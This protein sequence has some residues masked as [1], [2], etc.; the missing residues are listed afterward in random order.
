[1]KIGI[2]G[3]GGMATSLGGSF[4]RAGHSVFLGGRRVEAAAAAAAA[5]GAAGHGDLSSAASYGEVLLVAVPPDAAPSLGGLLT[6]QVV[7]DCT[8]PLGADLMLTLPP[9]DSVTRRL[10]SAAPGARVVKAFNLCHASV[11]TMSPPVFEGA[12]LVVPFC[13]DPAATAA[14]TALI[15][16]MGCVPA[17][18]GGL[19]R[20]AYLEATAAL[21]IGIWFGGGQARAAFPSGPDRN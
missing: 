15:R 8:N 13:G 5:I 10:A 12:P 16:S 1:M 4:V 6:G 9:G 14:M 21:A 2:L 20:A 3:T 18:C 7:V 11:W 17:D 19:D